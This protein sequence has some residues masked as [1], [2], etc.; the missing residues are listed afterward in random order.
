MKVN[1]KLLRGP[2]HYLCLIFKMLL[3]PE[4]A[5]IYRRFLKKKKKTLK[6]TLDLMTLRQTLQGESVNTLA[7]AS[8]N[9][10]LHPR[11]ATN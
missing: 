7:N 5:A 1:T 6:N 3:G 4:D 10:L 8:N 9:G 2:D 11:L